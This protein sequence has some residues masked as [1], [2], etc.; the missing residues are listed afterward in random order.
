[1]IG[2]PKVLIIDDSTTSCFY[3]SQTLKRAGY[4]VIT[5]SDGREGMMKIWQERPHCLILD[6]ILPGISGFALCRQLRTQ[7]ALRSLP[8]ILVSS[9]ST[10]MD[11]SWGLR[12]GANR[13]LPKPFTEEMLLQVVEEVLPISTQ[14]SPA[15]TGKIPLYRDSSST[16]KSEPLLLPTLIPQLNDSSHIDWASI[17]DRQVLLLCAAIDGRRSIESLCI[18]TQMSMA[19]VTTALRLLLSRQYIRFRNTS[20]MPVDSSLVLAQLGR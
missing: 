9:K 3:M 4:E 17:T 8:I 6:V 7:V 16:A 1:M 11:R 13:Y 18:I 14:P 2:A 19:E 12:Q 10:A 5:A 15:I 20:G